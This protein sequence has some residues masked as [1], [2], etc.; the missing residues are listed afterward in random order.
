MEFE[1]L[2]P[3]AMMNNTSAISLADEALGD[4]DKDLFCTGKVRMKMAM[5]KSKLSGQPVIRH[6]NGKVDLGAVLDDPATREHV[7]P[8]CSYSF[9]YKHVLERH[10]RQIHEKHLLCTYQCPKCTYSTVRKDQ[11]RSHFS[12]VHEDF[13]PFNCSE[14]NFRAPKAFRV[15]SHIEK[16]HGGI[17]SVIHDTTLKPRPVSPLEQDLFIQAQNEMAEQ[18]MEDEDSDL[19]RPA[20]IGIDALPDRDQSQLQINFP[21][22]AP[23]SNK[24]HVS[25][26]IITPFMQQSEGEDVE[27]LMTAESDTEEEEEE[28]LEGFTFH[29]PFC[30]F[31]SDNQIVIGDHVILNHVKEQATRNAKIYEVKQS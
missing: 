10:V 20:T 14:C 25:S 18:N 27:N 19:G 6:R 22:L 13:K 3:L 16:N 1:D 28:E 2:D 9:A 24:L 8:Y 5:E 26:K 21:E 12:V 30:E 4:L 23:E 29:C 15:T 17:G 7:C 11:M 31:N